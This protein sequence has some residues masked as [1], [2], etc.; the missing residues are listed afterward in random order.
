MQLAY[1]NV[2]L[3]HYSIYLGS[4]ILMTK[5]KPLFHINEYYIHKAQTLAP[6]LP[7]FNLIL[8]P[9][10]ELGQDHQLLDIVINYHLL[11]NDLLPI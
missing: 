11:P 5:F 8:I 6:F 4:F 9:N 7:D 2:S 10:R 3:R 1:Y